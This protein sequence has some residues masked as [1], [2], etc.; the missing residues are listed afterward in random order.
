MSAEAPLTYDDIRALSKELG[1]PA[2]TLIALAPDNDP[3][4]LQPSRRAQAM[5][6]A[7]L[8]KRLGASAGMHLRR[9]HYQVISQ[10]RPVLKL[11]GTTYENTMNCWIGLGQASRDARFMGLVPAEH[12]V[13]R[14]NNEPILY[15]DGA[16]DTD[17]CLTTEFTEPDIA[18][19]ALPSV[20]FEEPDMPER[21]C[22]YLT[23]PTIGQRFH[24]E[25]WCEKTTV[26]TVLEPL[27][28]QYG[29]NLI[30]GA[31]E[32]S[33]TACVDLIE[34]VRASGKPTRI[35]YISDFDPAGMGMPV[36]VARKVEFEI[37]KAEIGLD[38]QVR[39][40][41]L[42]HDQCER[43]RLPRTPMKET[44]K[45][46]AHF[47]GRF[48]EGATELDALE[49][50]H[51]RQLRKIVKREIE[52]YHDANLADRVRA[53]VADVNAEIADIEERIEDEHREDIEALD[54][55]WAKI[56]KQCLALQTQMEAR[57]AQIQAKIDAWHERARPTWQAMSESL[58]EQAPDLDAFDWPEPAE[59][60]EDDDP[61]FDSTRDYLDQIDRYKL[62][63][64]KPTER[65]TYGSRPERLREKA[66]LYKARARR[67]VNRKGTR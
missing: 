12:F 38:I 57:L 34:R 9:F 31:G 4:Y 20:S 32:Q 67:R 44:E 2:H 23:R 8:W 66:R 11:D 64:G 21:P 63:L 10:A 61:L 58:R 30:T 42:T 62:H 26:N 47:E 17:A 5:W 13:D 53:T 48:G 22:L 6:F 40:I 27:A 41:V 14:R 56:V 59:G 19:K 45:R 25:L 28:Q 33:L 37:R 39:P 16:D 1:R 3:F 54:S 49:A 15:L 29:C 36:A 50:L 52:R 35:L 7:D 46:M 43:Y 24:V 60:E 65:R 51:P 18:D 55:A